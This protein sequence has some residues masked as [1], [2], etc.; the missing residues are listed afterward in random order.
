MLPAEVTSFVGRRQ[1]LAEARRLLS[2]GRLV[3]LVGVGGVGKTRVAL[4]AAM[5]ARRA[6]PD[7]V[8]LVE[9]ARLR[10]PRLLPQAVAETLGMPAA[11]TEADAETKLA[12]YLADKRLLLVM[13]NCEHLAEECALLVDS[14]LGVAP[15][16]RVLATS[17]HVLGAPGERVLPVHPMPVPAMA[18]HSMADSVTLFVERASAI[19]PSF[20]VDDETRTSVIRICKRLEGIPLAIELAAVRLR[21]LSLNEI[22]DRL[23]DRFRLLTGGS[24]VALP[25]QRTLTAVFDWSHGLCSRAEQLLWARLS[26]FTGDFDLSAAEAV[27]TGDG[28]RAGDVF[29]I[30]SGLVDK[31]ILIRVREED[32][33]GTR[34]RYRMLE[35]VRQY[36][37]TLLAECGE[38]NE[39]RARHLAHYRDIARRY[40]SDHFGPRQLEWNQNLLSEHSNLR[41]ALEFGLTQPGEAAAAMDLATS[42]WDFWYSGGYAGEG[43]HW[44]SRAL[45]ASGEEPTKARAGALWTSGLL[46]VHLGDF[47]GAHAMLDEA[48]AIADRYDDL[49]LRLDVVRCQGWLVAREG[50]PAGGS[51]LL[52][53]VVDQHESGL[54]TFARALA[55]VFLGVTAFLADDPAGAEVSARCL[56]MCETTGATKTKCYALWTVAMHRWRAGEHRRATAAISEAIRLQRLLRDWTGL[57]FYLE[58]LAWCEVSAKQYRRAAHLLGAATTT[59]RLSGV[60][61]LGDTP[62][63]AFD[64]EAAEQA[65][66]ELG[67]AAYAAAFDAGVALSLDDA[68]GYALGEHAGTDVSVPCPRK[69]RRSAQDSGLTRRE[70]EVATLVRDGLTN[71]EIAGRLVVSPRTAETHVEHVLSKLGFTSRTQVAAWVTER[72][73]AAAESARTGRRRSRQDGAPA[74]G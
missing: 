13:D 19:V 20:V 44:L 53:E 26:V 18:G 58:T 50:D 48:R 24:R 15:G 28:V 43:H 17:R 47:E 66:R 45:T 9:L 62:F 34:A 32:A 30:M 41:T 39:A 74:R 3:T 70:L 12:E 55:L 5:Q 72:E 61:T 29:G 65:K 31:S 71:R 46:A 52:R 22:L 68:I 38:E 6:F 16:L 51:A 40:A 23:D 35:T 63:A 27:G 1:E 54:D 57:A 69:K 37:R 4:R 67:A 49:A 8:R 56:E 21:S 2:T 73:R 60:R 14:L 11:G 59:W 25:R 42:L 36:G 64:R 7:G 10:A 33:Y